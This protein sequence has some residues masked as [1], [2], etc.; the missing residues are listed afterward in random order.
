[1]KSE[2]YR[3]GVPPLGKIFCDFLPVSLLTF[4]P[5]VKRFLKAPKRVAQ[6]AI[7][8]SILKADL[9]ALPPK[10][11]SPTH[12]LPDSDELFVLLLHTDSDPMVGHEVKLLGPSKAAGRAPQA[13]R[14]GFSSVPSPVIS[15]RTVS[16]GTRNTGGFRVKPTPAGVPVAIMS[17]GPRV[18]RLDR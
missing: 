3:D 9:V 16:P 8:V 15:I 12:H 14:T 17:P 10:R 5:Q 11:R 7:S 6:E 13:S 4:V 2:A 18:R 1:M